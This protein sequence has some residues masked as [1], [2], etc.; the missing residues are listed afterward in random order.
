[1]AEWNRDISAAP[2]DG[3]KVIL[4]SICGKVITSKWLDP[5]DKERRPVGRWEFFSTNDKPVAWQ[6]YPT[7]PDGEI[8][9]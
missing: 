5:S 6:P 2:V 1:M 4:A 9:C 7:H 3:S 8:E